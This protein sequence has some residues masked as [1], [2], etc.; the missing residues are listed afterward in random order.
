MKLIIRTTM[1]SLLALAA[2]GEEPYKLTSAESKIAE[3]GATNYAKTSNATLI[4]C[5]NLCTRD[6]HHVACTIADKA[7]ARSEVQCSYKSEGCKKQ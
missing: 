3:L 6:D 2:H 4:S 1:I 7:G 5:S